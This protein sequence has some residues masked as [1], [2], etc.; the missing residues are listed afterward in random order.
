MMPENWCR[1]GIDLGQ[2]KYIV[3]D[4]LGLFS[5]ALYSWYEPIFVSPGSCKQISL[6]TPVIGEKLGTLPIRRALPI[7]GGQRLF[8]R[9]RIRARQIDLLFLSFNIL[10]DTATQIFF[11]MAFLSAQHSPNSQIASCCQINS[12][13]NYVHS[14]PCSCYHAIRKNKNRKWQ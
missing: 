6:L 9:S 4:A 10:L 7:H 11:S 8:K 1:P 2:V 3:P 5:L 12:P 14:H 13:H